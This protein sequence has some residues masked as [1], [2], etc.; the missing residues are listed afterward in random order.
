[1]AHGCPPDATVWRYIG[2]RQPHRFSV[3]EVT[4][5]NAESV[6][7]RLNE[8]NTSTH[9]QIRLDHKASAVNAIETSLVAAPKHFG[10]QASYQPDATASGLGHHHRHQSHHFRLGQS[11]RS[12]RSL[13]TLVR[14][15]PDPAAR[16]NRRPPRLGER[17]SGISF[18]S[19]VS[20]TPL[21]RPECLPMIWRCASPD[22]DFE[23]SPSR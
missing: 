21:F 17:I 22:S 8:S 6:H 2:S 20:T 11:E 13:A 9:L 7:L 23:A 18:T 5:E 15:R 3:P 4:P 14:R 1:M 10:L 12:I 16:S 19:V